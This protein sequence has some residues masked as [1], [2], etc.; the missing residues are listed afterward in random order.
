MGI[1][2]VKQGSKVFQY[3]KSYGKY[4]STVQKYTDSKKST[5]M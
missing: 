5:L 2:L 1:S 3:Q 4:N